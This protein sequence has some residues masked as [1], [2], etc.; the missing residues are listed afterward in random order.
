MSKRKLGELL[1]RKIFSGG[2][3]G[4]GEARKKSRLDMLWNRWKKEEAGKGKTKQ[5][6]K[7]TPKK[8]Q[9]LLP[10]SKEAQSKQSAAV[11]ARIK[12]ANEAEKNLP[13]SNP[14][15]VGK[16]RGSKKMEVPEGVKKAG[17][18]V[19][20]VAKK[21]ASKIPKTT[22]KQ[23][24]KAGAAGAGLYYLSEKYKQVKK[25]QKKSKKGK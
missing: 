10:A 12:R 23:K 9:K 1:F 24:V 13:K 25:K 20:K 15:A 16:F 14:R 8:T 21:A 6:P 4:Q 11:R 7:K 18:K 19:K 5:T 17:A 2:G 22:T 3:G